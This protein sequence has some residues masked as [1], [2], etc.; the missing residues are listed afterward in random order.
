[1]ACIEGR[2]GEPAKSYGHATDHGLW[3]K[4]TDIN[5]LQ[6]FASVPVIIN[7]GAEWFAG[8]GTQSSKGTRVFSLKGNV[9][10]SGMVEAP[11]GMTLR[12]IVYKIGGGIRENRRFK[13][14]T[15]GGPMGGFA[16]ES[17]LDL[18]VDYLEMRNAGLSL[19]SGLIVIDETNCVVD[20]VKYLLTFL[21]N[22]SCGKCTPCRDGLRQMLKILTN[23]CEGNGKENDIATLEEISEMQQIFAICGL[24]QGASVPLLSA[25]K[26]F[27]DEF[28]AHIKDK[29]CAAGVCK[30]PAPATR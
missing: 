30:I 16:P 11:M 19:G 4:P 23:I 26:H 5:N 6:T 2:V 18:P 17:L 25:I 28:D 8:I 12:D 10:N 22:E 15:V 24:G 14:V 20:T 27:R 21:A 1:M 3:G 9:K 7:N 13:A 29:S